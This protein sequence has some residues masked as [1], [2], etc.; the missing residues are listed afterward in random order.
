MKKYLKPEIKE[1]PPGPKSRA[2]ISRDKKVMSKS[3]SR[4]SELVAKTA[5]GIFVQ[6]LDDNVY[7]D[8]GAGIA[9]AGVGHTHPK[10]VNAIKQQAEKLVF[11]NSLDYYSIPQVD[12]AERLVE[13]TPGD[14]KK[15]VFFA[16]SGSESVDGAIKCAKYYNRKQGR[17]GYYGI[18]FLGSFHGRTMGAVSFTTSN[19]EARKSFW[20]MYAGNVIV[21]YADCYHCYFK[22]TYPDCGL[23]CLDHITDV[24]FEKMLDA[25]DVG[26][27]L[28]EPIQGAGGYIVPPAEWLLGIQNFANDNGITLI[29]DE[30]QTGF[31]RTGEWFASQYFGIVPDIIA[32][33]KAMAAGMPCGAFISRAEMQDWGSGAHEGTLNG[34]PV[35]MAAANA[36]LDIMNEQ[37]L[38][39]NAKIQGDYLKKRWKEFQ[40]TRPQIGDVRG[41]GLMVGVEFVKDLETKEPD[42]KIRNNLMEQAFKEGLMLLGAGKNSIRLCPPL[43]IQ[44][45][46]ID[47]AMEIVESAW[48]K[49]AK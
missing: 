11:I 7:I 23:F 46:Q 35:I 12:Y 48:K 49:I 47:M 3:L 17:G 1:S 43:I 42:P 15:R 39:K 37:N 6:D 25:D 45:D 24:V 28:L 26:F 41:V 40:E 10:V 21:P 32:V 38:R 14:F 36:V 8:F 27:F 2:F 20:P 19:K 9:V 30:V 13:I 16:N 34:N 18:G 33:S 44:Q 4:S 29:V 31:A 22:Q 5:H